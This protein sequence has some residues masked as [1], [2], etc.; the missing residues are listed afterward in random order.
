MGVLFGSAEV[1][2][3]GAVSLANIFRIPPLVIG[4]TVIAFGTSLPELA[5]S[6]VAAYRGHPDMVV[7]NVVGS[8]SS[9]S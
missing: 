8:N 6:V 9:T 5:A 1:F 7:G 3:R 4:L 2:I